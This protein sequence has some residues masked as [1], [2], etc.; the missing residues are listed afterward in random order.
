MNSRIGA[1]RELKPGADLIPCAVRFASSNRVVLCEFNAAPRRF[2]SA[3][4]PLECCASLFTRAVL[5]GIDR[6]VLVWV[7]FALRFVAGLV[8]DLAFVEARLRVWADAAS[9]R[10]VPLDLDGDKL[11][12]KFVVGTN[13]LPLFGLRG[14]TR[15]G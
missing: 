1:A 14:A 12:L 10:E 2:K 8:A 7:V 3:L 13:E 6:F 4:M 11:G 5:P 9:A 15:G